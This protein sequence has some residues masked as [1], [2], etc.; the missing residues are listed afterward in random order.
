MS[1]R[2]P[3]R[4]QR[5]PQ[6]A[7]WPLAVAC[8]LY[9]GVGSAN[10]SGAEVVAG[11]VSLSQP[12]TGSLQLNQAS[13]S[14]IVNWQQFSIGRSEQV[15]FEQPSASAA[16]L[17]RVVGGNPSEILG[18]LS[19][20]GRV[21]LV[22]PQG[23]LFGAGSQVDVGSLVA[24]TLDIADEDFLAG[25]LLFADPDPRHAAAVLN[26]GRIRAADGGYVVLAGTGVGNSGVIE[27][28][29]GEVALLS[30]TA[31]TLS[32]DEAGLVGFSIDRAA[33]A[34]AAGIDNSGEILAT[35]GR[36]LMSAELAQGLSRLAINNSG[37]VSAR[38][39]AEHDGAIFLQAE[40]GDIAHGGVLDVSGRNGQDGG[41]VR[42]DSDADIQLQAGSQIL[43]RGDGANARGG[44]VNV[45][46][47]RDLG[48]AWGAGVDVRGHAQGGAVELSGLRDLQ[49]GGQLQI[50]RGGTLLLDP[51]EFVIA[52]GAS[53]V[54][55]PTCGGD[56][57]E[58]DLEGLL[59]GGTGITV[60]SPNGI[61]LGDLSDGALDGRAA[62]GLGGALLFGVGSN[63]NGSF[64]RGTD[65]SISF[66]D[67]ND[68]ILLDGGFEA[69]AGST[70]GIVDI[71]HILSREFIVVDAPDGVRTASLTH[72][73][74]GFDTYVSLTSQF[75]PVLSGSIDARNSVYLSAGAGVG[76]SGAILVNG[77][78][79]TGDPQ[80]SDIVASRL[81]I[82]GGDGDIVLDGPVTVNGYV[83]EYF[84]G[85][86]FAVRGAYVSLATRGDIGVSGLITLDGTIDEV[87]GNTNWGAIASQ[88]HI[89]PE[90][91]AIV[92]Q[93][94][95]Q[96][97]GHVGHAAGDSNI[98]ARGSEVVLG[99]D[100]D[101]SVSPTSSITV[102]GP[103][104]ID[105]QVD[106]LDVN[107]NSEATGGFLSILAVGGPTTLNGPVL[108][109]GTVLLANAADSVKVRGGY[110]EAVVQDGDLAIGSRFE[111]AGTVDEVAVDSNFEANGAALFLEQRNGSIDLG[112]DIVV[113]GQLNTFFASMNAEARGAD[114]FIS[115]LGGGISGQGAIFAEGHTATIGVGSGSL[116]NGVF[117][118]V[119]AE[120]DIALTGSIDAI[121]SL[122]EVGAGSGVTANAAQLR[123]QGQNIFVD[124][125]ITLEGTTGTVAAGDS[126]F[127][128]GSALELL[129][130]RGSIEV[131]GTVSANGFL[132]SAETD[133]SLFARAVFAQIR[134]GSIDYDEFGN[135][136]A[137]YLGHITLGNLLL[138]GTTG[139]VSGPDNAFAAGA[140]LDLSAHGD[141][142]IGGQLSGLGS[143][144]SVFGGDSSFA[145]AVSMIVLADGA[146]TIGEVEAIGDNGAA[147]LDDS[148]FSNGAHLSLTGDAVVLLGGIEVHGTLASTEAGDLVHAQATD[149]SVGGNTIAIGGDIVLTGTTG[150]VI[151]G[152]GI[153]D[154]NGEIQNALVFG[155][156]LDIK[157]Q[158]DLQLAGID[159]TGSLQS[160]SGS[161]ALP[162]PTLVG[163]RAAGVALNSE[164]GWVMVNGDVRIVG[165]TGSVQVGSDSF[166]N[167][168]FLGIYA[169]VGEIQLHG[170]VNAAG[171]LQQ[172]DAGDFMFAEATKVELFAQGIGIDGDL[173][174]QGSNGSVIGGNYAFVAGSRLELSAF[175]GDSY[176]GGSLSADGFLGLDGQVLVGVESHAQAVSVVATVTGAALTVDGDV[177][178][179][180]V[181]GT[182]DI[183]FL[184]FINGVSMELSAN[185]LAVH[186]GVGVTGTLGDTS[187][188][189]SVSAEAADLVIHGQVVAIDGNLSLAG[190]TGTVTIGESSSVS[191][192]FLEILSNFDL[193]IGGDLGVSGGL[194]AVTGIDPDQP[195]RS[196][197]ASATSVTL[198]TESSGDVLIGGDVTM[199]GTTGTV[200]VGDSSSSN[201][202]LLSIHATDFDGL[203]YGNI[204]VNG[205]LTANGTI[206]ATTAGDDLFAR[207]TE[208]NMTTIG[209]S[210]RIDGDIALSGS[211]GMADISGRAT[212]NAISVAIDIV[213]GGNVEFGG[214]FTASGSLG[215]VSGFSNIFARAT[216]LDLQILGGGFST[217]GDVTLTGTT[218]TVTG[219]NDIEVNA[220]HVSL[221]ARQG[222]LHIGGNLSAQGMLDTVTGESTVTARGTEL[223]VFTVNGN[224]D[225]DGNLVVGG[226]T[227]D[228]QGFNE[229]FVNGAYANLV[230]VAGGVLIGGNVD[231]TGTLGSVVAE[232]HA[233]ASGAEFL[234]L[235][236]AEFDIAGS[237]KVTGAL[238]S[239]TA[240]D[241]SGTYGADVFIFS[242]SPDLV[243]DVRIGGAVEV[244]GTL[245]AVNGGNDLFS[246]GAFASFA[247]FLGDVRL[248][249]P[250][251]VQGTIGTAVSG[252]N[253]SLSGA[254]F[255]ADASNGNVVLAGPLTITGTVQSTDAANGAFLNGAFAYLTATEGDLMVGGNLDL[256]GTLVSVSGDSMIAASG[257]DLLLERS[258]STPGGQLTV[259]GNIS[260]TGTITTFN[261]LDLDSSSRFSGGVLLNANDGSIFFRDISAD[262][263]FIYFDADS[264]LESSRLQ[265][266]EY[267]EIV[268]PSLLPTLTAGQ[269][270]ISAPEVF[271]SAN[272]DAGSLAISA[273]SSLVLTAATVHGG[274]V[275]LAS[276]GLVQL[277][278]ADGSDPASVTELSG[279]SVVINGGRVVSDEGSRIV[280]GALDVIASDTIRLAGT[281]QVGSG[282]AQHAG[283]AGLLQDIATQS[284]EL[285]PVSAGP[286]AYFQAPT[287][288]LAEL[289]LE[290]DYLQI[291]ANTMRLGALTLKPGTL[292]HFD[293]LVNLPFFTES[294]DVTGA[295]LDSV[296]DRLQTEDNRVVP[297][298]GVFN[299]EMSSDTLGDRPVLNDER[300]DQAGDPQFQTGAA[301][302]NL[303]QLVLQTGL[304]DTTVAIGAS[305]YSAAI[306]IADQLVVDV[307]PSH[308][309]FLF[310]TSSLILLTEPI[311][312]N[313]RV[314]ILRGEVVNDRVRFYREVA[315][316]ISSYYA[317][318]DSIS[319]DKDDGEV[320]EKT[321]NEEDCE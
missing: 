139:L 308:T 77:I 79:G 236:D 169:E 25:R 100:I 55:N 284:P 40:G 122:D 22:N 134:A 160:V 232:F 64:I 88:I 91:G 8:A 44:T 283:D 259:S 43:A 63:P 53:T 319:E 258:A 220:T 179:N 140:F 84:G 288:A 278:E 76:V 65:G 290:G 209:G 180:G 246:Y 292:V 155:S 162:D 257:A 219:F 306:Q 188:G 32:T 231:M 16:V 275:T 296:K 251:L 271:I 113:S 286:N 80:R 110:A 267:L 105:G 92:L 210:I 70:T 19:A 293:P 3:S 202:V 186:G 189:F 254:G 204:I 29:L 161:D 281:V 124:G 247:S 237:L 59:A 118:S 185:V 206:E 305:D 314:Q 35:G 195:S 101:G 154:D 137:D 250:V 78:I 214:S 74:G 130:P 245:D 47:Q 15:R 114:L 223:D 7:A 1:D 196:V 318:F 11:Q 274:S 71:G 173:R 159:V 45:V 243:G 240:L 156:L 149:V 298:L 171:S 177:S 239:F 174:L 320:E 203:G 151:T 205:K 111:V 311:R 193:I 86:A 148:S 242:G 131:T 85:D 141:I 280:A 266:R 299:D 212:V 75:G 207:A 99:A 302:A 187:A 34:T 142:G 58:Q 52:D 249:A 176:I 166:S 301:V 50:G 56:F 119:V 294:V 138:D 98:A 150:S 123:M 121:G 135:P 66:A 165:D 129:T 235:P 217:V 269:L 147:V 73:P 41:Q 310:S 9:C 107:N 26:R 272:V 273:D 312:T 315:D 295:G 265:A 28:R 213:Q 125:N 49:L 127:V 104:N 102:S 309:N 229:V 133:G 261:V 67:R 167:G 253:L 225:V 285:L 227:G 224:F 4:R 60:T 270:D 317:S 279:D 230:T 276:S 108:V 72:A 263:A 226:T 106:H 95:M 201:G 256:A 146:L 143:I 36:V 264:L 262:N 198:G 157:A 211:N 136:V 194:A 304:A 94:G 82:I 218:G 291:E 238:D 90:D 215:N 191:G 33:L 255:W 18:N 233:N 200:L 5:L 2:S 27:A 163:S 175:G 313:G 228:V 128:A 153:V 48:F 54:A 61:I 244:T 38:S 6:I 23:V 132:T 248:E 30:G 222:D 208:V 117:L 170:N 287:V 216:E 126:V 168:A 116:S 83:T 96:V 172:I 197:S 178:A 103:V 13:H 42:V 221:D 69:Y 115:A 39:I 17:N 51:G 144:Q 62:N 120:G 68:A 184:S 20:N 307:L 10:P 260:E 37:R 112:G 181:T 303:G 21:F 81:D 289:S 109:S 93:G 145:Q 89:K 183:G 297:N 24:S 277:A 316:Q 190:N 282:L 234:A 152:E 12:G 97:N 158:G 321:R 241:F 57:C 192:S 199:T 268:T 164:G 182:T 252:D 87:V 14:A 300:T 31:V 46:A